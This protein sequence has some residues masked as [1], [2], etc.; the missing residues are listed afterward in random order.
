MGT[1]PTAPEPGSEP[2]PAPGPEPDGGPEGWGDEDPA[3]VLRAVVQ[4]FGRTGTDALVVLRAVRGPGGRLDDFTIVADSGLLA[5][6][7]GRPALGLTARQ[8]LPPASAEAMV[9]VNAKVLQDASCT[10]ATSPSRSPTTA[11]CR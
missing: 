5:R 1:E 6:L 11:W 7:T 9:A 8:A 4:A 3:E 10:G 2:G